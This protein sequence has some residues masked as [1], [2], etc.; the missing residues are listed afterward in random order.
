METFLGCQVVD[1]DDSETITI[2]T[3]VL[4]KSLTV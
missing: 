4:D 3:M 1:M 2:D